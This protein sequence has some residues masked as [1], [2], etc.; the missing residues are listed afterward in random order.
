VETRIVVRIFLYILKQV[1]CKF[2]QSWI[3]F[4]SVEDV[5]GMKKNSNSVGEE[6]GDAYLYGG[7]PKIEHFRKLVK[8]D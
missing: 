7:F 3:V 2:S 6:V 1:Q 8:R 5:V 4:V